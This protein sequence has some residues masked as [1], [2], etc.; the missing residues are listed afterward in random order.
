MMLSPGDFIA[1][2]KL[3]RTKVVASSEKDLY[4]TFV[5]GVNYRETFGTSE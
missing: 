5:K 1:E 4:L 2:V 3:V